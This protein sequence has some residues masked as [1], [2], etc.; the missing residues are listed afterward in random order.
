VDLSGKVAVVT[1]AGGNLGASVSRLLAAR[2]ATVVLSDINED[3]ASKVC[4]EITAGG[5]D[6]ALYAAD[7]TSEEQVRSLMA[8]ASEVPGCFDVLV[9]NAGIIGQE[10]GITLTELDVELW[11]KTFAINARSV[12]L[13]CK[14]AV[15]YMIEQ[16]G[17]SIVNVSSVSSLAGYFWVNAYA[18]SKAAVNTLT[19]YVA[20]GYGKQNIRCN[21]VLPGVH[22]S[23]EAEARTPK[24]AI[25]QLADHCML[26]RLGNSDDVAKVVAFL[27]SDDSAYIT[28][29]Y[30]QVDGGIIDHVPQLAEARRR[31]DGFYRSGLKKD[32]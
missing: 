7:V 12:M 5:G 8:F 17:G 26:P 16:G 6:A 20:T 10:H 29:Q 25:A 30:I 28:G 24:D 27:A 2:G 23:E 15:P 18:S 4:D 14:H 13:A 9:N 1:G 3:A 32:L 11:D 19:R 22:L 21:A 31:G